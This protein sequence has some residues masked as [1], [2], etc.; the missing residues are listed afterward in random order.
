MDITTRQLRSIQSILIDIALERSSAYFD[1]YSSLYESME[2][3]P[4][5]GEK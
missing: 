3:L 2:N 5:E 1:T 4:K